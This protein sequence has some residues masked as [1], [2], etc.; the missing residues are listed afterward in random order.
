MKIG[1]IDFV[2]WTMHSDASSDIA[3]VIA[4]T[5]EYDGKN[6]SVTEL[7]Y[8]DESS[9][10]EEDVK[11]FLAAGVMDWTECEEPSN[12]DIDAYV[13]ELCKKKGIML[14]SY[15][16]LERL[17]QLAKEKDACCHTG[18]ASGHPKKNPLLHH[19]SL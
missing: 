9:I 8:D 2:A 13:Q 16:E 5:H 11:K 10:S 3:A 4:H 18:I 17:E 6:H 19:C 14:I 12:I 1:N 7:L 15:E